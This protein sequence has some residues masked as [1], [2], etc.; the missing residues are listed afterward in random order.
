VQPANP[1]DRIALLLA[2]GREAD[3]RPRRPRRLLGWTTALVALA[4]ALIAT[5]IR[6]SWL[7]SRLVTRINQELSWSLGPGPSPAVAFPRHGPYDARLG[8]TRVARTARQL[9][10]RGFEIRTQARLSPGLIALDEL[11]VTPP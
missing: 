11:G 4:G 7:Q 3:A 9:A 5:E 10:E 8:Y 6:T 2:A 1:I